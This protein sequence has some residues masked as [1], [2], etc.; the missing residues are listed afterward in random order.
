[1]RKTPSPTYLDLRLVVELPGVEGAKCGDDRCDLVVIEGSR[2]AQA[3]RR[4]RPQSQD[5]PKW[6]NIG[7]VKEPLC[8]NLFLGQVPDPTLFELPFVNAVISSIW[9]THVISITNISHHPQ[10]AR[11]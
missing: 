7:R 11:R 1:M 10:S 5:R 4:S 9:A 6:T 2:G 3:R 8:G